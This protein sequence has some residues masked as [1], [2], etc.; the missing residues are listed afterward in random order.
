WA[1]LLQF[2]ARSFATD[3]QQRSR[4][5]SADQQQRGGSIG[6][7]SSGSACFTL[8][9][10]VTRIDDAARLVECNRVAGRKRIVDGVVEEAL[11]RTIG[12]CGPF[13]RVGRAHRCR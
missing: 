12:G 11:L 3:D 7:S 13:P 4:D 10:G 6:K 9:R 8:A 2:V 5:G 1:G